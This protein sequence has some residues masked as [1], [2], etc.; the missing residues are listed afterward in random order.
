MKLSELQTRVLKNPTVVSALDTQ[1]AALAP[2]QGV[3]TD[4]VR[5]ALEFFVGTLAT[6]LSD[7]VHPVTDTRKDFE[8]PNESKVVVESSDFSFI[9]GLEALTGNA[10]LVRM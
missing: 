9:E 1:Q 4:D 10:R 8:V 2:K 6:A 3:S 7:I 5:Q